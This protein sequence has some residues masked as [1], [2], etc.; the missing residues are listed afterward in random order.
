M[1]HRPAQTQ[2]TDRLSGLLPRS[3]HG[4]HGRMP[5]RQWLPERRLKP[6]RERAGVM[7]DVLRPIVYEWRPVPKECTAGAAAVD[8]GMR[9]GLLGVP[10]V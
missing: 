8:G 5:R 6:G 7:A 2:L 10:G 9:D 1:T 4:Q 3:G